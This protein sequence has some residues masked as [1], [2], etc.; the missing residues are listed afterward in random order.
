LSAEVFAIAK[1]GAAP[2]QEADDEPSAADYD[3]TMDM[4]DDQKRSEL[5]LHKNEVS[6]G[7]YNE[8]K[9]TD[10]DV[11]MREV[12]VPRPETDAN[13]QS[14]D[15]DNDDFDMF[16]EGEDDDMFAPPPPTN[17]TETTKAILIIEA[18]QL[19]ASLLDDWDDQDGYYKM[20]PGELLDNQYKVQMSL[21]KGMFS[22]VVRA[23]DIT[24]GKDSAIKI[25]RNNETMY[26]SFPGIR[27]N[28]LTGKQAKS[29]DEGDR[30]S[31]KDCRRGSRG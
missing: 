4:Q 14:K 2:D 1:E 28:E 11:L 22:G 10:R 19:D 26:V 18:K 31:K 29:G 24:T 9:S 16:A 13:G 12:D 7:A 8:M 6:S 3:P 17:K 5:R 20:I 27:M 30:Y 25:I 15:N 23:R 21:G